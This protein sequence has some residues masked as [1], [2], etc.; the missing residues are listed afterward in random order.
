MSFQLY[1]YQIESKEELRHGFQSHT[2][3][4]LCIPTGGGKTVVFSDISKGAISYGNSVMIV[5][6]RK[7][8]IQQSFDKVKSY[9]LNPVKI[10][11][12]QTQI[13]SDCY[14]ASV[15]TLSRRQLFPEVDL[16][17]IDEAHKAKFDKLVDYYR[18]HRQTIIIGATAT[19]VR[20]GKQRSLH[21][22]Y[23]RI[24]DVVDVKELISRGKLTPAI[25]YA[26]KIDISELQ[27]DRLEYRE[28]EL[29]KFYNKQTLYDGVVDNYFK[30]CKGEPTIVFNVNREHSRNVAEELRKK[31][32]RAEHVDGSFTDFERARILNSFYSGQIDV[33]CNCSILTT[34]YDNP[35]VKNIILNRATKS[36]SLFLQMCGRGSRID[37]GKEQFRVIDMGSNI[38]EHGFWDDPRDWY[39]QKKENIKKKGTAPV[40]DC[41]QCEA[42]VHASSPVCPHCQY[43]FP[44]KIKKLTKAEFEQIEKE[45]IPEHLKKEIYLMNESELKDYA[46]FK[47]Y[48]PGWVSIQIS[49][50]ES[51]RAARKVNINRSLNR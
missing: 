35:R 15:D 51:R 10:V 40:K 11:P 1:D 31:G 33:V 41:P 6:D 20:I 24:V 3:Q 26:A 47:G 16:L 27:T 5:C 29:F 7:E 32:V 48:K 12:G 4:I 21:T 9:G 42:L 13:K 37:E 39:L 43:L 25:Y 44:K 2:A 19:P 36:L 30:F 22:L 46:K 28:D 38:K 23:D 18:E 45:Q 8:L 17:I 49:L 14:V 34:G 50:R